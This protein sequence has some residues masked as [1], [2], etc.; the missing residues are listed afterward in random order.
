MN[1]K[2]RQV[3]SAAVGCVMASMPAWAFAQGFPSKA[4]TILV[5]SA[6]GGPL[7]AAARAVAQYLTGVWGVPVVVDHR[8]G[9]GGTIAAAALARAPADGLTLM[10]ATRAVAINP[11]LYEK[12]TFDT[13]NDIAPV[14]MINEQPNMLV[15]PRAFPAKNIPEL[16]QLLRQNPG[17][18]TFGSAGN[19]GI[20]HMAGEMFMR[21]SGTKLIHVPYKG[22]APLL[23]DLLAGRVDM[24]FASPPSVASPLSDGRIRALAIASPKRSP[25]LPDVATF[26]EL[27]LQDMNITSWYGL[28]APARTSPEVIRKINADVVAFLKTPA[29][30]KWITGQGAHPTP[31]SVQD[32]NAE[33]QRDLVTFSALLKSM[34]VKLD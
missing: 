4:V 20:P 8:P 28:F 15:V 22:T 13:A 14:A 7:D 25:L 27:G 29:A 5:A 23:N 34:G 9:A 19:G 31:I 33:F 2:R 10:L 16:I 21:A 1:H 12:L 26:A 3:L 18:Y 24:T 30:I 6:P 32:F 11:S 17:K